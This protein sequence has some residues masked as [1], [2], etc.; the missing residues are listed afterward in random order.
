M[1]NYDIFRWYRILVW[2][3]FG[4][5]DYEGHGKSWKHHGPGPNKSGA[6]ARYGAQGTRVEIGVT[7]TDF[8]THYLL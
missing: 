7:K 2:S 4:F 5:H 3:F 6:P 1:S 8:S